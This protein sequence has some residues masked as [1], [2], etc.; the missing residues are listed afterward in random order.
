MRYTKG[1][2]MDATIQAVLDLSRTTHRGE[3]LFNKKNLISELDWNIF[4]EEC[5][6]QHVAAVCFKNLKNYFY[7]M[8]PTYVLESLQKQYD[9]N[10]KRNHALLLENHRISRKLHEAGIPCLS[11]K[12]VSLISLAYGD[13]GLRRVGDIDLLIPRE[14]VYNVTE[15]LRML[16]YDQFVKNLDSDRKLRVPNLYSHEWRM[17]WHHH[18]LEFSRPALSSN[19]ELDYFYVEIHITLNHP[20]AEYCLEH[21]PLFAKSITTT[22]LGVDLETLPL[23]E[24]FLFLCEHLYRETRFISHIK[25]GTDQRLSKYCDVNEFAERLG[26]QLDWALL[27]DIALQ[28][29]MKR[30]VHYT[31]NVLERL[32]KP[33]RRRYGPLATLMDGDNYFMDEFHGGNWYGS[34]KQPAICYRWKTPLYERIL[35]GPHTEEALEI[36]ASSA[37]QPRPTLIC[38]EIL[39]KIPWRVTAK[40]HSF[41]EIVESRVPSWQQFGTHVQMGDLPSGDNDLSVRFCIWRNGEFFWIAIEV[42][43]SHVVRSSGKNVGFF[44]DQDAVRLLICPDKLSVN[45]YYVLLGPDEKQSYCIKQRLSSGEFS[46]RSIKTARVTASVTSVGYAITLGIPFDELGVSSASGTE[47]G[48]DLQIEDCDDPST[49]VIRSMV[50]A[51]GEM[52]GSFDPTVLGKVVLD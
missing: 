13:I 36:I 42:L 37:P 43:D 14:K 7:E 39:R 22:L 12:G 9:Y 29:N 26:N 31:L 51:G 15:V 21:E 52:R 44:Y 3:I 41:G 19:D 30:P 8:T 32:F 11:F 18:I 5:N 25:D 20:T 4:V 28:A 46:C 1:I 23:E 38:R 10:K 6:R 33:N 16:G 45:S 49:G 24:Y 48:F 50:W 47:F 35:N 17:R 40:H 34:Q 2:V 27:T